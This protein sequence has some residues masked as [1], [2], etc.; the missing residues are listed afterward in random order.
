[1]PPQAVTIATSEAA[2]STKAAKRAE[3][4]IKQQRI[5]AAQRA[6]QSNCHRLAPRAIVSLAGES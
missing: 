4:L 2:R 3:V 6:A 5:S 1:L